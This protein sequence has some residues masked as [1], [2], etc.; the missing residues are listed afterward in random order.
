M[1]V[2]ATGQSIASR[3]PS[4][5]SATTVTTTNEPKSGSSIISPSPAPTG[6]PAAIVQRLNREIDVVLKDAEVL[7]RIN[8]F[9][10]GTS[11]AGT[12]QSTG[13]FIRAERDRWAGIVKELDIQPQ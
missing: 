10:L 1:A 4:S 11:G 8:Q 13:E 7:Q 12:P 3:P 2:Q 9:G 6:T 5:P